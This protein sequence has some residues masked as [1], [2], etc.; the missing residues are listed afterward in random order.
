[1][2]RKCRKVVVY[3]KPARKCRHSDLPLRCRR[4]RCLQCLETFPN[5]SCIYTCTSLRLP[6]DIERFK[7]G[8]Y[9]KR[10]KEIELESEKY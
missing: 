7:N 4:C 6:T 1:M 9:C 2:K 3:M 8:T 5:G 10:S